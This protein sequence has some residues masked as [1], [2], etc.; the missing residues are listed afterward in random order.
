[1]HK[2]I[3]DATSHCTSSRR[4]IAGGV[5]VVIAIILTILTHSSLGIFGM[6]LV[7]IV[8]C[9]RNSGNSCCVS[10]T[11]EHVVHT[12]DAPKPRAKKTADKK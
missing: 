12:E 6:F 3:C 7:G 1:M 4:E 11:S 9:H 2:Y 8:L 5:I 10:D